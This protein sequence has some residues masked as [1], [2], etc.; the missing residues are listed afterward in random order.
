M[1][2]FFYKSFEREYYWF[3]AL[4]MYRKIVLVAAMSLFDQGGTLQLMIAQ[5]LCFMYV[6]I[7]G[8]TAPYKKDDA[9]FTNTASPAFPARI[10][11]FPHVA[12]LV[13]V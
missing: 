11:I 1:P 5:L 9:D 8:I 3:E 13:L 2:G 10:H 4:D 7:L 12:M 6:V